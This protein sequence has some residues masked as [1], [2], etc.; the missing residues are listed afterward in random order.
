[1]DTGHLIITIGR[2]NGSGGREVGQALAK[3]LGMK[4][5]DQTVITETAKMAGLTE[6][7]V[8]DNE[9]Q[10]KKGTLMFYGMPIA[11]P[12]YQYQHDA[13]RRIAQEEGRGVFVG[14][15][16][17]Y[18][19]SGRPDTVSVFISASPE[20]CAKRSAKRNNISFEAAMKRTQNKNA[21]RSAYYQRYTGRVWG[22]AFYYDLC[23][24]TTDISIDDTVDLI[25]DYLH[26]RGYEC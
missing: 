12:L 14:R 7:Q 10:E 9:E 4:C 18:V 26:K 21:N 24:N 1:M 17:D 2:M 22:S 5:Y 8:Y 20:E 15:S 6:E 16:A 23:L 3:R 19:L 11:N 25:L 13:I